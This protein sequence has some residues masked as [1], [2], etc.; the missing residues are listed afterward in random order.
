[1]AEQSTKK[2]VLIIDDDAMILA[3]LGHKLNDAG[4]HVLK[5]EDADEAIEM[6][7][8]GSIHAVIT[9]VFM[10]GMGGNVLAEAIKAD[11]TITN[12]PIIVMS[13]L[14]T[15]Q[16][17]KEAK[18]IGAVEFFS[19]PIDMDRLLS[20]LFL[21]ITERHTLPNEDLSDAGLQRK[22]QRIV[23]EVAQASRSENEGHVAQV[24]VNSLLSHMKLENVSFWV[25]DQG[26]SSLKKLAHSGIIGLELP[27]DEIF[28]SAESALTELFNT[29]QGFYVNNAYR[30]GKAIDPNWAKQVNLIAEAA[31]P[32]FDIDERIFLSGK[33]ITYSEQK[34]FGTI[35]IHR[36]QLITESEFNSLDR[37][38]KQTS[39]ILAHV[40]H[41]SAKMKD[42][43]STWGSLLE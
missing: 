30:S 17:I 10:P 33:M 5:A 24:L 18:S 37:L 39:S 9:D 43:K 11:K 34:V 32:V 29:K 23:A 19:K 28:V 16:L 31:F 6:I 7:K 40:Y 35:L 25:L 12:I 3:L 36:T 27:L 14:P 8:K 26:K 20:V 38:I 1:M 2:T 41:R 42:N 4:Y 13:S 22:K 15:D 21:N